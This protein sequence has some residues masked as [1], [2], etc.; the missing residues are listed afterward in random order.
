MINK[1]NA[2]QWMERFLNGETT[3][4]EE[5][6]L[7]RYFEQ[8][9]LPAELVKYKKMMAWYGAGL[10]MPE[11]DQ[12]MKSPEISIWSPRY[13]AVVAASIVAIVTLGVTFMVKDE[14][15]KGYPENN[16]MYA[17]Y[18]GSY[19]VINGYRNDNLAQ[20]LPVV[21]EN[22]Y[23]VT[24]DADALLQEALEGI[25]DPQAQEIIINAMSDDLIKI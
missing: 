24:M 18:Q 1:H 6:A 22:E 9:E 10:R 3:C 5:H 20:I 13:M 16:E 4:E 11:S 25:D 8:D 15:D 7:F 12:K 21:Q 23:M 14:M 2:S 17:D 19:V